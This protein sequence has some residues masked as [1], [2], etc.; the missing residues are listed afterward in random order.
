M[1]K[2]RITNSPSETELEQLFRNEGLLIDDIFAER[3]I[4][5]QFEAN[6]LGASGRIGFHNLAS[7]SEHFNHLERHLY[8]NVMGYR[9]QRVNEYLEQ[10]RNIFP[11]SI[12]NIEIEGV[13]QSSFFRGWPRVEIRIDPN[14]GDLRRGID[15]ILRGVSGTLGSIERELN[16]VISFTTTHTGKFLEWLR[17]DAARDIG[18]EVSAGASNIITYIFCGGQPPSDEDGDGQAD[19]E[20]CLG[21][22][23]GDGVGGLCDSEGN[24]TLTDG[25]GNPSETPNP[26]QSEITMDDILWLRQ[27]EMQDILNNMDFRR[28]MEWLMSDPNDRSTIGNLLAK[29]HQSL[30]DLAS[31][32]NLSP[33]ERRRLSQ[34]ASQYRQVI[35]LIKGGARGSYSALSDT[36]E[37]LLNVAQ[38]VEDIEAVFNIVSERGVSELVSQMGESLSQYWEEYQD[39]DEI[40]RAEIIGRVSTGVALTFVPGAAAAR[41]GRTT[42]ATAARGSKLAVASSRFVQAAQTISSRFRL[43]NSNF[44]RELS[45]IGDVDTLESLRSTVSRVSDEVTN[46]I[47]PNA[48]LITNDL[49]SGKSRL[50]L[51]SQDG[52]KR[53]RIDLD[54]HG[55]RPH[56]HLQKKVGRKK[57]VD[58]TN[59]HR[60]YVNGE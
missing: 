39:A 23:G 30:R 54:G 5:D 2:S 58:V 55:D 43:S 35:E 15:G 9:L 31:K 7:M 8:S 6:V 27:I 10:M 24:C 57:W 20:Q 36:V 32:E 46:W 29:N 17:Q 16:K 60:I 33:S 3:F 50:I 42:L 4:G 45:R 37:S 12:D 19:D 53:F 59:Q 52:T 25:Q 41:I 38:T 34:Q 22:G 48:R 47:G 44:T 11:N 14:G 26:T 49:N 40:T 18:R 28:G 21:G 13:S 56:V 51:L 1:N